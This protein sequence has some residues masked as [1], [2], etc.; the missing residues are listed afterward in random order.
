M[1]LV[2]PLDAEKLAEA[3]LLYVFNMAFPASLLGEGGQSHLDIDQTEA[4]FPKTDPPCSTWPGP[5]IL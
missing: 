5:I 1:N 3:V 2:G 4:Y